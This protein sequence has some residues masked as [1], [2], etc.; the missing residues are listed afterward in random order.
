MICDQARRHSPSQG[1]R[2][3][4]AGSRKTLVIEYNIADIHLRRYI[5]NILLN[6]EL[7]TV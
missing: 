1:I 2:A 5:C 7:K 4:F 6:Q 3:C